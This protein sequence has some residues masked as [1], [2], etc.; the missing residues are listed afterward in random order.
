MRFFVKRLANAG[1]SEAAIQAILARLRVQNPWGSQHD[2]GHLESLLSEMHTGTWA[3]TEY[4]KEVSLLRSGTLAGNALGD[5][6][7]TAAMA[8]ILDDL[9]ATLDK[10]G[11]STVFD[12]VYDPFEG[13][14]VM[15]HEGDGCL[16]MRDVSYVDDTFVPTIGPADVV[17]DKVSKTMAIVDASFAKHGLATNFAK[18]KTEIVLAANGPGATTL[19]Q[20][21]AHQMGNKIEFTRWDGTK[22]QVSVVSAYK[23]LGTIRDSTE[24][25]AAEIKARCSTNSSFR[26]ICCAKILNSDDISEVFKTNLTQAFM[27]SR[28]LYNCGTW[29]TLYSGE[30]TRLHA[31]MAKV[32]K[33]VVRSN[34]RQASGTINNKNNII[35]TTDDMIFDDTGFC[36][37]FVMLIRA[38]MLLL[39][40]V[41]LHA[42]RALRVVLA[43]ASGAKRSWIRA[44]QNDLD[45]LANTTEELRFLGELSFLLRVEW[46]RDNAST[47]R[48]LLAKVANNGEYSKKHCWASTKSMRQVD[49][50]FA[51]P[52]CDLKFDSKQAM[53][54]HNYRQH[55]SVRAIRSRV[56][57]HHC[58]ACLQ[59]FGSIERVVCHLVEKA[60]RCYATYLMGVDDM[61]AEAFDETN[62]I[63]REEARVCTAE[64]RKRHFARVPVVRLAGPHMEDAVRAGICHKNL[65]RDGKRSSTI[66]EVIKRLSTGQSE[67]L[68]TSVQV[69]RASRRRCSFSVSRS[70]L[71][72]LDWP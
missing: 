25:M 41:V 15:H 58:I 56:S 22:C 35:V 6:V 3:S 30:I 33:F 71:H 53:S 43:A 48:R 67:I 66:D 38:R 29:P 10:E 44:V 64:G 19:K 72:G 11:L 7:F 23:H 59:Y 37:P 63:A 55:G 60:S 9:R 39:V 36:A 57:T 49:T 45:W 34:K 2:G 16:T 20:N 51:C 70:P 24:S 68:L 52:H 18:G 42:P 14:T 65:L 1:L 5:L 54:V 26:V 8:V 27:L 46:I 40:R 32:Y 61:S 69:C 50:E 47:F 17:L 4:L 21:M 28:V 62:A 13:K 31:A 12:E